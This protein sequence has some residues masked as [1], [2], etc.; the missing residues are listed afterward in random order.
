[1]D[2]EVIHIYPLS[3]DECD[4][5]TDNPSFTRKVWMPDEDCPLCLEGVC[6]QLED[7]MCADDPECDRL[8][9]HGVARAK[10]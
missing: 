10:A 2:R 6:E 9:L 4:L 5:H 7:V 1:M 3:L 8:I